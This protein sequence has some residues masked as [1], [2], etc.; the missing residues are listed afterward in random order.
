MKI[1][2]R[3]ISPEYQESPLFHGDEFFPDDIILTGNRD[4]NARTVPAYDDIIRY[5][6]D[7]AEAWENESCSFT[8]ENGGWVKHSKKPGCSLR[9][10]LKEYGFNREDGKPWTTQQRH[11]WRLLLDGNGTAE[12]TGVILS[13]L[14]LITGHKWETGTI[15][16]TCQSDWQN[17]IYRA[18]TWSRERLSGFETEYF[19]TGTEWIIHDEDGEPETPEEISGYSVYCTAWTDE[20]IRAELADAAGGTP[21]DVIMYEYSGEA[22]SPIYRRKTA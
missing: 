22:R 6:D 9:D 7:M 3:Q 17:V 20:G 19:N 1:Y 11:K 10:L 12:D 18:D 13:A 5:F 21:E 16:G 14:E 2:A 8:Y 4:Y 15:R